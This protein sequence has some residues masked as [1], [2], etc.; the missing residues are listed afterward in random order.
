VHT[1]LEQ[2]WPP[3]HGLLQKPQ[4]SG[5]VLVSEQLLPHCVSV[6]A[7][8]AEHVL[9]EQSGVAPE[10]T[11]PQLPQFAGSDAAFTHSEA[12]AFN[13]APQVHMLPAQTWPAAQAC[14]QL[15]QL[16]ISVA[17]S[18]HFAEQLVC[19]TPHVA[20]APP[21]PPEPALAA[22]PPLESPP[23]PLLPVPPVDALNGSG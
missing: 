22:A 19:P 13:P 20:P 15:P 4:F 9:C 11:V 21:A 18:T 6:P 8:V 14:A 5:S 10:Q 23:E 1:L 3:A 2:D 16:P 17:V 12:H 7:Q